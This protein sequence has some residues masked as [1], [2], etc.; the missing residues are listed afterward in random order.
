MSTSTEYS[1][2]LPETTY[3]INPRVPYGLAAAVEGLTK[4]VLRHLPDD[5]Y[6]FAAHHF[7]NLLKLR[8]HCD[9]EKANP[10]YRDPTWT[11]FDSRKLEASMDSQLWRRTTR[12]RNTKEMV[13]RSGWSFNETYKVLRRHKATFGGNGGDFDEHDTSMYTSK[14]DGEA[15]VELSSI[16]TSKLERASTGLRGGSKHRTTVKTA[17]AQQ[18]PKIISY[19]KTSSTLSKEL[20][21]KDIKL[22]LRK[23]KFGGAKTRSV[24]DI[25]ENIDS[26]SKERLETQVEVSGC[27]KNKHKDGL[28]QEYKRNSR[29]KKKSA[30]KIQQVDRPGR[31]QVEVKLK[32]SSMDDGKIETEKLAYQLQKLKVIPDI[33]SES[34]SFNGKKLHRSLSVD[35]IKEYMASTFETILQLENIPPQ[36]TIPKMKTRLEQSRSADLL[37]SVKTQIKEITDYTDRKLTYQNNSCNEIYNEVTENRTEGKNKKEQRRGK[38][39]E[40]RNSNSETMQDYTNAREE[41]NIEMAEYEAEKQSKSKECLEIDRESN[42]ATNGPNTA[43]TQVEN[44]YV[45]SKQNN[46]SING[47]NVHNEGNIKIEKVSDTDIS[48][49]SYKNVLLPVVRPLSSGHN[50]G[51]QRN[52]NNTLTLPPISSEAPRAVKRKDDL[53]LPALGKSTL[54]YSPESVEPQLEI[55]EISEYTESKPDAV[56]TMQSDNLKILSEKNLLETEYVH[57]CDGTKSD[58]NVEIIEIDS[59]KQSP[60]DVEDTQEEQQR[61]IV[62]EEI[63]ND[64]LNVTPDHENIPQRPDSLEPEDI[65]NTITIQKD[66][67]KDKLIEIEMAEKNIEKVLSSQLD[68]AENNVAIASSKPNNLL[69]FTPQPVEEYWRIDDANGITVIETPVEEIQFTRTEVK[70]R[71]ASNGNSKDS[72]ETSEPKHGKDTSAKISNSVEPTK[73]VV[74]V[75]KVTEESSSNDKNSGGYSRFPPTSHNEIPYSYILTEGSP[76]EIPE[77]VTTVVIPERTSYSPV[78]E[79]Y[80]ENLENDPRVHIFHVEDNESSCTD[81]KPTDGNSSTDE[82]ID[83]QE[84]R[85]AMQVFGE[86]VHPQIDRPLGDVDFIRGINTIHETMTTHHDLDKIKEEEEEKEEDPHLQKRPLETNITDSTAKEITLQRLGT[87][88]NMENISEETDPISSPKLVESS[89]DLPLDLKEGTCEGP[90]EFVSLRENSL[91]G[92]ESVEITSTE[93]SNEIK[94]TTVSDRSTD[95]VTL[96]MLRPIVPELNLD[97]LQDITISSFKND[98]TNATERSEKQRTSLRDTDTGS[99]LLETSTSNE[100]LRNED[101]PLDLEGKEDILEEDVESLQPAEPSEECSLEPSGVMTLPISSEDEIPNVIRPTEDVVLEN[102]TVDI[103]VKR[104]ESPTNDKSAVSDNEDVIPENHTVRVEVKS[105]ES[106]TDIKSAASDNEGVVLEEQMVDTDLKSSESLTNNESASLNKEE[107]IPEQQTVDI[108]IKSSEGLT[109][110]QSAASNTKDTIP[111]KQTVDIDTKSSEILTHDKSTVSDIENIIPEKEIMVA[112]VKSSESTTNDK[113]AISEIEDVIPNKQIVEIEIEPSESPANEESAI[114]D[115][116]V[117]NPEKQTVEIEV[118]TSESPTNDKSA[119]SDIE[120]VIPERQT[121]QVEIESSETPIDDKYVVSPTESSEMCEPHKEEDLNSEEQIA[122]E[123]IEIDRLESTRKMYQEEEIEHDSQDLSCNNELEISETSKRLESEIKLETNPEKNREECEVKNEKELIVDVE[124]PLV[125]QDTHNVPSVEG[126]SLSEENL[127]TD[128]HDDNSHPMDTSTISQIMDDNKENKSADEQVLNIS[129]VPVEHEALMQDDSDYTHGCIIT[130]IDSPID[131]DLIQKPQEILD[132][133]ATKIQACVRGFLTRK[134]LRSMGQ[135][136]HKTALETEEHVM[137]WEKKNLQELQETIPRKRFQREDAIQDTT[138]S[139]EDAFMKSGLQHTGE[140]HDCLPLPLFELETKAS[141][142]NTADTINL[143]EITKEENMQD[144]DDNCTPKSNEHSPR[145]DPASVLEDFTVHDH[146]FDA[147]NDAYQTKMRHSDINILLQPSLS[148]VFHLLQHPIQKSNPCLESNTWVD[149][150]SASALDCALDILTASNDSASKTIPQEENSR[151]KF[152]G[153]ADA[154]SDLT[155]FLSTLNRTTSISSTFPPMFSINRICEPFI[156]SEPTTGVIIE[157]VTY[158][159]EEK[160]MQSVIHEK[161]IDPTDREAHNSKDSQNVSVNPNVSKHLRFTQDLERRDTPL[162]LK[163]P[164]TA[165]SILIRRNIVDEISS[166]DMSTNQNRENTGS[167]SLSTDKSILSGTPIY[168]QQ[169]YPANARSCPDISVPIENM[170]TKRE[171]ANVE[172]NNYCTL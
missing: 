130:E 112:E 139:L 148:D 113:S 136:I 81:D 87:V 77:S 63:F 51:S 50:K 138:S 96:D 167:K 156:L 134:E 48:D 86:Y 4:E 95:S 135:P 165:E 88:V 163:R 8:E 68:I 40:S 126:P 166:S 65:E 143:K 123:L 12:S 171:G 61:E 169:V 23:N 91:E 120:V 9:K 45:K 26:T 70:E 52:E 79:T 17:I 121:E 49:G 75:T 69:E 80:D 19:A 29:R 94:E 162:K 66:E 41:K 93:S 151:S 67:L 83:K 119:A 160:D 168:K 55:V 56:I 57:T 37:Q 32:S 22:K 137:E 98:E 42:G 44:S 59:V 133:A 118:K 122:R 108:E 132:E 1:K 46:D 153:A 131:M 147:K 145:T 33:Q 150:P 89:T 43:E 128:V 103:E 24:D 54:N 71:T 161:S 14:S 47:Q 117:V 74:K 111:E 35:R 53:I 36:Q 109:N 129:I 101:R 104:A 85:N 144:S 107:V 84:I 7:E 64:S 11:K 152:K 25:D 146:K 100:K 38:S 170:K 142:C 10:S 97:S 157:D 58:E 140:F 62:I 39:T 102:Q 127:S 158:M 20:L 110:D 18:T 90:R 149:P 73:D 154:I 34:K 159:D 13:N 21:A 72:E 27:R 106:H 16:E 30:E 60:R 28:N 78:I 3:F 82:N 76:C 6:V 115:G 99:S 5:I 114:S 116:Q 125:A 105:S 141:K 31:E 172:I 92:G 155:N 124:D 164:L 2:I 15:L